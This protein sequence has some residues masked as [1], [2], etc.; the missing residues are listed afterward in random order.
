[1]PQIAT[2]ASACVAT[3]G[4]SGGNTTILLLL[5]LQDVEGSRGER[6]LTVDQPA[7]STTI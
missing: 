2:S 7:H 4:Y 5:P 1:M 6:S 3:S